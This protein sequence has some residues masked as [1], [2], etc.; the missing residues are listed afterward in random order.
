MRKTNF[1]PLRNST[2][3]LI[4]NILDQADLYS[5]RLVNRDLF[6]LAQP[7]LYSNLQLPYPNTIHLSTDRPDA[8]YS[9]LRTFRQDPWLVARIRK[10]TGPLG[11]QDLQSRLAVATNLKSP[12]W[13]L[14]GVIYTRVRVYHDPSIIPPE[15]VALALQGVKNRQ[16]GTL[17][18]W[19]LPTIN[20]NPGQAGR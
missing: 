10:L 14:Y 5:V 20:P 19:M 1:I 8:V 3:R 12:S 15:N 6:Q 2:K 13:D 7:M 4:L 16:Y 17:Q 18:A 9:L 11:V